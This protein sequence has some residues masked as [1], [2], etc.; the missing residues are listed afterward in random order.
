MDEEPGIYELWLE[1]QFGGVE[2]AGKT[3]VMS[4]IEN[5]Y[6][7]TDDGWESM[8]DNYEGLMNHERQ[9]A[10]Q[11]VHKMALGGIAVNKAKGLDLLPPI[12]LSIDSVEILG[13]EASLLKI[14]FTEVVQRILEDHCDNIREGDHF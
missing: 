13:V 1:D 2:N 8:K 7:L 9:L 14:P 4:S 6:D 11:D 3:V 5:V 12:W 10:I